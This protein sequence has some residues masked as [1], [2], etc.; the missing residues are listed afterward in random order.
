MH[1]VIKLYP[2]MYLWCISFK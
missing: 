2:H 1:Q